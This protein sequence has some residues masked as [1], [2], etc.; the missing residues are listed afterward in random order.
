METADYIIIG[1]GSAGC[2]LANRLSEDPACT[3]L[4]VEAGGPSHGFLFR[5]PT[6]SY[7][8]L[9]KPQADWMHVTEPDPTL[10]GRQVMWNGGRALGGGSAINGMVYVRGERREFDAWIEAGCAGWGWD[11]V[12]P[13][14]KRSEDFQGSPMASHGR[15]GPLAVSPLRITHPI[16]RAFVEA[17]AQS[18]VRRL[19][20]YCAGDQDGVFDMLATQK[21]GERWSAARGYLEPALGRRNLKV[22]T[23]ALADRVEFE[24]GRATGVRVLVDG[25]ARTLSARREVILAAGSVMS[26]AILLRSGVGPGQHL[27][28]MGLPVLRDAPGVGRNLQEHPSFALSRLVDL[29]TYNAMLGPGQLALHL[30]QFALARRGIMTSAAVQAMAFIRSRPELDRPDIKLS[31]APFCT[32]LKT[33]GMHKQPGFSVFTGLSR[34]QSRGEIRLRSAAA[35]D[36]PV[37][38]HRLFGHEDDLRRLIDGLKQAERIFAAPAM[39]KHLVGFNHPETSPADDAEWEALVRRTATI[40]FHPVGTCRMGADEGSVVDLGLA[41]RGV[42][43]LR[44]CDAS[45]MPLLNSANTNAPVMM[46]AEK[47]AD[48]IRGRSAAGATAPASEMALS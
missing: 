23:G 14:F 1:G 35:A 40:G 36:K 7:T 22:I 11:D 26:P 18:G 38:D 20:D 25:A 3:V 45:V 43:G 19:E 13:Y 39:A 2:V 46:L 6:G 30:A 32:D 24:N 33:R 12:L 21:N 8:M 16:T 27:Q 4:L 31:F 37:I 10:G 34:P 29:P 47:A 17:C 15:G 48:L 5:M 28:D 9:G 42:Q 44:V 41:V